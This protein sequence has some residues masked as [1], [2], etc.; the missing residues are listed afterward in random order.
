MKR[1]RGFNVKDNIDKMS[2]YLIPLRNN[3]KYIP[4]VVQ[5]LNRAMTQADRFKLDMVEPKLSDFKDSGN[6]QQDANVIMTL[7]SPRRHELQK[8]R[9]YDITKLK[10]RFRS[11]NILKNRDGAADVRIGLQFV[12]EVGYFQEIPKASQMTESIYNEIINLKYN[13][14]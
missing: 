6:T 10:D 2:E 12:G 1:E 14:K 5:Q 11:I 9:D 3:F 7:F 13:S 8:F 4:V